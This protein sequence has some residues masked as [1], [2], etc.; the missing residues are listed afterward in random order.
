MRASALAA[1][2][3]ER[4]LACDIEAGPRGVIVY[5]STRERAAF[6][7]GEILRTARVRD[8]KVRIPQAPHR[9]EDEPEA[10]SWW[11]AVDLDWE[12]F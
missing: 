3:T 6:I 10:T 7:A 5:T 9:D 1:H 2:F 8:P 11:V 4:G 12:R